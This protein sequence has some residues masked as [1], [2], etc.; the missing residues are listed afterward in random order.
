MPET[1]V[2]SVIFTAMMAFCMVFCMSSYAI[3]REQGALSAAVLGTVIH[4]MWIEY[5]IA[6]FLVLIIMSRLAMKLAF[7]FVTP[8]KDHPMLVTLAIQCMN[9]CLMAPSM[10]L[11]VTFLHH[12]LIA[13][14]FFMWIQSAAQAIPAALILQVFFVGPLVRNTFRI[15]R[16]AVERFLPETQEKPAEPASLRETA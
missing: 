8:G 13:G 10:T 12:G 16:N 9:V 6:F 2:Q 14:W 15:G 4:E 5:A 1:K 7:R 3:A 11:V